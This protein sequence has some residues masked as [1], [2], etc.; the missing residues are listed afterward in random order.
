M[1]E[2]T[3]NCQT[4]TIQLEPEMK[5]IKIK[6]PKTVAQLLSALKLEPETAIVARGGKLLTYDQKLWPNDE[7]FVRIVISSG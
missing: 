4:I 7:L 3:E 2:S 1:I 6:R 5:T